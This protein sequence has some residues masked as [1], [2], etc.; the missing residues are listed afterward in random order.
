[1]TE[2]PR[3]EQQPRGRQEAHAGGIADQGPADRVAD[4][5][6]TAFDLALAIRLA[7]IAH[8]ALRGRAL[9]FTGE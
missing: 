6:V 4:L 7:A 2:L 1:M 9:H 5:A 3:D 8:P